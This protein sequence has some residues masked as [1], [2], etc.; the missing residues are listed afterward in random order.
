MSDLQLRQA[1]TKDTKPLQPP[2]DKSTR[3]QP[4]IDLY[5]RPIAKNRRGVND[6]RNYFPPAVKPKGSSNGQSSNFSSPAKIQ[7][8]P[9]PKHAEIVTTNLYSTASGP[10][11]KSPVKSK[12]DVNEG[13]G[14][15]ERPP[16]RSTRVS[17]HNHATSAVLPGFDPFFNREGFLHSAPPMAPRVTDF[18]RQ[19]LVPKPLNIKTPPPIAKTNRSTGHDISSTSSA[20]NPDAASLKEERREAPMIKQTYLSV[21]SRQNNNESLIGPLTAFPDSTP[22]PL[23][24]NMERPIAL[25]SNTTS[26]LGE[27]PYSDNIIYFLPETSPK[28]D[29]SVDEREPS[30]KSSYPKR[31]DKAPIK[32]ASKTKKPTLDLGVS[33]PNKANGRKAVAIDGAV[34]IS[35]GLQRYYD[36][37]AQK[38]ATPVM[39]T[40]NRSESSDSGISEDT[41]PIQNSGLGAS[42]TKKKKGKGLRRLIEAYAKHVEGLQMIQ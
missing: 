35:P 40:G 15:G 30:R 28:S 17:N 21:H 10:N 4:T 6:I 2:V 41:L 37:L 31:M 27:A 19:S 39:E 13:D 36:H 26:K 5:L 11:F 7:E 32:E 38:N 1:T 24:H 3:S 8:N 34:A 18:V 14:Q 9:K 16:A 12:T 29:Q 23:R 25:R 20:R 42:R 22:N 33:H